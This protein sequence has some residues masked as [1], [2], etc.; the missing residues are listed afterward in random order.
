[1]VCQTQAAACERAFA[2]TTEIG[3]RLQE[4]PPKVL[5][6]YLIVGAAGPDV[7]EAWQSGFLQRA[8]EEYSKTERRS[9]HPLPG[10]S[11]KKGK[12]LVER[13]RKLRSD[14]GSKRVSYTLKKPTA[15][16]VMLAT[17]RK[18]K[19][20]SSGDEPLAVS[21]RAQIS[22]RPEGLSPRTPD[23]LRRMSPRGKRA[24]G[25]AASSEDE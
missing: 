6:Q 9:S 3:K 24:R 25:I 12:R 1:M 16:L 14:K 11:Y 18:L 10:Q 23:I 20:K 5:E 19:R 8:A 13:K 2:S 7:A 22:S 4:P 15:G 17:A 21:P